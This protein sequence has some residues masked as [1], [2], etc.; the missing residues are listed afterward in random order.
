M[1]GRG[2]IPNFN[3]TR[4]ILQQD[5]SPHAKDFLAPR[6]G[7]G[8]DFP[9]FTAQSP[10][11]ASQHNMDADGA[12]GPH[13]LACPFYKWE[14]AVYHEC[15]R[16]ELLTVEDVFEHLQNHPLRCARCY[17]KLS[18]NGYYETTRIKLVNFQ[19]GLSIQDDLDE[20]QSISDEE[21]RARWEIIFTIL[22][23]E[24]APPCSPFVDSDCDCNV[25]A[26]SSHPIELTLV[27]SIGRLGLNSER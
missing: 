5:F 13:F 23:P 26:A 19:V 14:P 8:T 24:E 10:Q 18:S 25:S 16:A 27:E 3:G 20:I 9:E 4:R 17:A 12:K 22:F 1:D 2:K 6:Y 15:G 7:P 11:N 21:V